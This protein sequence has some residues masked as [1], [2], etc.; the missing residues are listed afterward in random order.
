MSS[1]LMKSFFDK[2]IFSHIFIFFIRFRIFFNCLLAALLL[3]IVIN[4]GVRLITLLRHSSELSVML[5]NHI[6][7]VKYFSFE[8]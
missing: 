1:S 3:L 5:T 7:Y 2:S 8:A 4:L 6:I